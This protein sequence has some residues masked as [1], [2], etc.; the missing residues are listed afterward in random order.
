M[1]MIKIISGGQTGADTAALE[2]AKARGWP[3]GGWMPQGF[4]RED[5]KHPEFEILYGMKQ[6]SEWR[7]QLRTLKNVDEAD[8]TLI[9]GNHLSPGCRLTIKYCERWPR[10]YL[11]VPF[12]RTG[13]EAAMYW[14]LSVFMRDV[15]V[16]NVAGNREHKNPG[17]SEFVKTVLTAMFAE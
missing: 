17:I 15:S 5:G 2:W 4:R 7:Y 16:L 14:D 10:P 11:I 9:F 6:T 13:S 1:T 3:T 8:K 12:P